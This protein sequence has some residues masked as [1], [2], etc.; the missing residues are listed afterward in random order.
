[1]QIKVGSQTVSIKDLNIEYLISS[2]V[3]G[4]DESNYT[5]NLW[6][7]NSTSGNQSRNLFI[8]VTN[9]TL[10]IQAGS[11]YGKYAIIEYTKTTDTLENN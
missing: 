1:M 3:I 7:E 5:G 8:D 4:S 9:Q 6:L 11:F 10:V 2:D